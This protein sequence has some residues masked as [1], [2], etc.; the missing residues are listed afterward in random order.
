MG[1]ARF[2]LPSVLAGLVAGI[3]LAD[4]RVLDRAA[5]AP[6]AAVAAALCLVAAVA[7]RRVGPLTVVVAALAGGLMLGAWRAPAAQ[8]PTGAGTVSGAVGDTE[9]T[10]AGTVAD[11]PRSRGERSQF[12]LD[13]VSIGREAMRL[14]PVDGRVLVWAPRTAVVRAGDRVTLAAALEEP[15]DFEGFAYRAY[16][17]RQGIGATARAYAVGV[18]ARESN[19]LLRA[20]ADLRGALLHGLQRIL[21]EPAAA[22]AAGILLGVR[23]GIDEEVEDDFATAGLT[24]VVAIS[25]WNIAIVAGCAVAALAPLRRRPGGRWLAPAVTVGAIGFY[26]ILT[27][28]SPSV[29]RAALMAGAMVIAQLGGSRA[30]AASALMLASG[31][32]LVSAPSV[33]W[34]V[35]FQLSALATAGLIAAG[36]PIAARLARW[37]AVFREPVA[38]TLAAQVFT[39]PVVILNFERVSLVAPLANVLVVPLVPLVMLL[40]A[41][42]AVVGAIGL[43]SVQLV[44][45]A[46][47]WVTGGSAWLY[48]S[49]MIWI[50]Q[51][52]ASV[53][54]AAV[55]VSA[56]AWLIWSYYPMMGALWIGRRGA[57][58]RHATDSEAPGGLLLTPFDLAGGGAAAAAAAASAARPTALGRVARR[59]VAP[60]PIAAATLVVVAGCALAR[61]PDGRLHI[62]TLDVGQGDAILVEAGAGRTMLIDGG[63][64]PDR[65]LRALAE[66]LPLQARHIDVLVLTHPH[67]DHVAGLIEVLRRYSVDLVLDTGRPYENP[68][69]PQFLAH[70]HASGRVAAARAGQRIEL[71]GGV[72]F[73]ILYPTAADAAAPLPEGDIN[74]A[75]VVG[76]VRY[77]SFAALL[78]GDAE[79]PVE[80]LLGTRGAVPDVDLLKVGHHGSESSTSPALLAASSPTVATISTG[81]DNEYGHPHAATLA[82][83]AGVRGLRTYRT[84]LHG[85]IE[86]V[87][88]GRTLTVVT[89]HG[90]TSAG[91]TRGS[92]GRSAQP[93]GATIAA[94]PSLPSPPPESCFSTSGFPTRSWFTAK[95]SPELPRRPLVSSPAQASRSTWHSSRSPPCFTTSTS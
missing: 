69:Y 27:G 66:A 20:A 4:A 3:L 82:S 87:T 16:L 80:M 52:M 7:V 13:R 62:T 89:S 26:V 55:A 76:V 5:G 68:D 90:R 79:L 71:G 54:L 60:V 83:L 28:G 44:G 72:S 63:P 31:V 84:D 88:D 38:L 14:V 41:V 78:T 77:G 39:L 49:L 1:A 57:A 73:E 85:S 32:M 64:D 46:A 70:A 19:P 94:W 56:P 61:A 58:G 36:G 95:V 23:G 86:V 11:E 42:A 24:H 21:P 22:L 47:A 43:A 2:A 74:N 9:W 18:V 33:L 75:S 6:L 35:G 81:A 51:S 93:T 12:V 40:S 8:L 29:V 37:P 91:S 15:R 65:T 67:R 34:D 30:H 17:A 25:G 50:G 45:D 92:A 10:I 48:L 59:L 53:P